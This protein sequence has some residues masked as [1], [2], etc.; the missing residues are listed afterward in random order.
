MKPERVV[1][2]A[3][4][5]RGRVFTAQSHRA[6]V[7]AAAKTL[8]LAP[9]AIWR[10]M[11]EERQGFVTTHGRW[12]SRAEAWILAKRRGQ[13]RRHRTRTGHTPE[14]YSEDVQ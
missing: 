11:T 2:A 13:L 8:G 7:L 10:G 5:V 14:L 1:E 9:A 6:A 12:L 4:K 3:V